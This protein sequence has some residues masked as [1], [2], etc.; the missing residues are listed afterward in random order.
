MGY[1][2]FDIGGTSVRYSYCQDINE[3]NL[4]ISKKNFVRCNNAFDEIRVNICEI[5]NDSPYL[6]EGIGISIPANIDRYTGVVISW[7][8]NKKWNGINLLENL[9]K[10]YEF[11][12]TIE[13]DANCGAIGEYVNIE[14]F[15]NNM[16]YITLGTGIGCGLILNKENFKGEDGFAAGLII[17]PLKSFN[18][19]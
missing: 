12:I 14:N 11:P 7:P 6:V 5:I 16:A 15:Y 2:F 1:V 4:T 18:S 17:I 3:K 9:K 19:F 13:D 8:N 10:I